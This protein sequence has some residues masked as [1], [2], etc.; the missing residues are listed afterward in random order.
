[1]ALKNV[2]LTVEFMAWD[3]ANSAGK[4][5]DS[6]NFTLKVIK[7]GTSG[8]ATNAAAEIDATNCPGLYKIVLTATEMNGNCICLHGKSSTANVVIIPVQITTDQG[9]LD[10]AVT[11][12]MATFSLPTN[13]A[14]LSITAGGLADITQAA[15][16]KVWGSAT[17]TLSAFSTA[18]ALS[19]WDVLASA[20]ATASSIGLQ[21]KTDL[22]ATISS[23]LA[24]GSYT[25]P[26]SAATIAAAVWDYLTSAATTVGSLGKLLVDNV[27]ATI[28][29]RLASASYTAP[30]NATVATISTNLTTA[31]ARLGSWTGTGVN[32]ILGAIQAMCRKTGT[33]P[34]DIAGTFDLTTD[35]LQAIRD[36]GDAAWITGDGGGGGTSVFTLSQVAAVVAAAQADAGALAITRATSWSEQLTGLGPI[37]GRS[38]LWFTA[39]FVCD[40]PDSAAVIQIEETAGLL[41]LMGAAATANQGSLTV[42]D[43]AA[44]NVTP[45]L[46]VA[47]T[48]NL[49]VGTVLCYDIK[50]K[51]GANVSQ[52]TAGTLTVGAVV[53]L[54]VS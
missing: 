7:D 9:T 13:F 5:G 52:L 40:D 1:M 6:G 43:E 46:L 3:T 31:L 2:T 17:R 48:A 25:A 27:N 45:A 34:T 24:T 54:A 51:I 39:K 22:D 23:R 35:S 4:T 10:A 36:R 29:S 32:T 53:T 49:P 20:V 28:S 11:S 44:G 33:L 18:L 42:D 8:A 16:D 12:R 21:V 38:K 37:T 14:A 19:V 41:R 30:D 50:V 15:A 26:P 47:A